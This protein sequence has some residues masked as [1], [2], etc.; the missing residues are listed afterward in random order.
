M[1]SQFTSLILLLPLFFGAVSTRQDGRPQPPCGVDP[2]PGYPGVNDPP[3]TKFWERSDFGR[4]WLP[5]ACTGWTTRGFSTLT[6]IAGRFRSPAGMDK[7]RR[8]L[9]AISEL[10]GTRYWST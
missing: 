7:M 3:T 6:V 1:W 10:K 5:P 8:R 2:V 4:D 9:G